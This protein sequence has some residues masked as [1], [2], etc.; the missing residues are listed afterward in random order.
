[1]DVLSSLLR[2]VRADGALVSQSTPAPPW[3]LAVES[4][5][6]LT[7][8]TPLRGHGWLVLPGEVEPVRL[9]PG[10][11]AVVTGPLSGSFVDAPDAV[12][13]RSCDQ[14]CRVTPGEVRLPAEC[15]DVEESASLLVA[16]FPVTGEVGHR[17]LEALPGLL[18]VPSDPTCEDILAVITT[19]IEADRPGQQAV[20]ERLLEWVL[21]CTLR[22]WFDSPEGATPPWY[23][24]MADPVVGVALRA[25]HD[26]HARPWTV[27]SLAA[28]AGVSR[29]LLAKRFAA[30]VGE[31]PLGYLTGWRMT[32]AADLLAEPGA[33]VAQVA[34]SVG[35]ADPF[36]FSTAFKRARGLSP[37]Q[38]R[39]S[40][41][42]A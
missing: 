40:R 16:G 34:R 7:L 28:T 19:E 38:W 15:R 25:I 12:A 2:G 26:D 35:Y 5:A 9:G 24:A 33:T 37:S 32:V 6:T 13:A 11:T 39:R 42:G 17:L 1:M 27:A 10:D 4:A 29:A 20:L 14:V 23:A 18:V 30:L 8:C 22:A 21:V 36:G 3:A 31:P 41:L